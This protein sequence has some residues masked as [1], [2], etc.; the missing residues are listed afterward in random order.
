MRLAVNGSER[1]CFHHL[2]HERGGLRRRFSRPARLFMAEK[3]IF[4]SARYLALTHERRDGEWEGEGGVL[5]QEKING[6]W[7]F[8]RSFVRRLLRRAVAVSQAQWQYWHVIGWGWSILSWCTVLFS[9]RT[10]AAAAAAA[11]AAVLLH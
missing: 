8:G 5:E 7:Y 3:T 2:E 6:V 1:A 10:A 4:S 9:F 11:A